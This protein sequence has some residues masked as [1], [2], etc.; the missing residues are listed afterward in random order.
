MQRPLAMDWRTDEKVRNIG[1]Q[2]MFGPAILVSPVLKAD[3]NRRNV[4]L[5]DSP[6]WYDF[7]SGTST[8]GNREIEA[9]A[10][11]D[12]IPLFVRAG[13]ILPL[14]PEIEYAEQ[15]PAGPIELRVYR[16]A[17]AAFNLYQDSGDSY[18]YEKGAH[19]VIPLH[20]SEATR[21]LTIGDR[22]GS[23]P[24]MPSQIEFK[25]VWV[26]TGHGAGVLETKA[27]QVVEYEGKAVT[28]KA[29]SR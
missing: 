19:S 18:D 20:W 7:W 23:Y 28:V 4:Y 13:S 11:L 2:F 21:T 9:Y 5:P 3:A 25:V 26:S 29:R 10:P 14:G 8:Q 17:D 27:D 24:G 16:G 1:D 15:K 6:A 22:V 12:R